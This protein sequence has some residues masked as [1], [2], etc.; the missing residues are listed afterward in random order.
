MC[1][2]IRWRE[3]YDHIGYTET[4]RR[5]SP[6][7]YFWRISFTNSDRNSLGSSYQVK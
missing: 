4:T 3:W 5:Y 7:R 1:D 6:Y 2:R